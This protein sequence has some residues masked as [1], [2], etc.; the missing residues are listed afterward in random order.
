[1][2]EL[3]E[4]II[5][6]SQI[7]NILNNIEEEYYQKIPKKLIEFFKNN[8]LEY[9]M[10]YNDKGELKISKLAE[11]IL[12]YLNLEYWSSEEEKEELLKK[13]KENQEE[14]YA[15]YDILKIF[16]NR[17]NDKGNF[18]GERQLIVRENWFK[19]ILRKIRRIFK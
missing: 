14:I 10:Y 1:M 3:T 4:E 5:A 19:K 17:K 9:C 11:Q 15:G 7:N 8:S 12:C 16:E 2:I 13:Y 18:V 6:Y